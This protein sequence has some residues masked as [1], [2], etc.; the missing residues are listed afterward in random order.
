MCRNYEIN[1]LD[2][3]GCFV[4]DKATDERR[5]TKDRELDVSKV[6][7]LGFEF[8]PPISGKRS[9][10]GIMI[11]YSLTETGEERNFQLPPPSSL[12]SYLE[13]NIRR[14]GGK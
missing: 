5:R 8:G 11:R 7:A 12:R 9:A 4:R 1:Y 14:R 3:S 2:L 6:L 13:C 10:D